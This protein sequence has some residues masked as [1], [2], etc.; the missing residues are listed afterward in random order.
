MMDVILVSM[1]A[2]VCLVRSY[3]AHKKDQLNSN[4]D[5]MSPEDRLMFLAFSAHNS[6][7][8]LC[9]HSSDSD[10]PRPS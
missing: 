3:F 1:V 10:K 9:P 4:L 7:D 6:T 5:K 8:T 2:M